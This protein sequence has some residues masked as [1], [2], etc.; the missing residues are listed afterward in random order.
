MCLERRATPSPSNKGV[1]VTLFYANLY[2]R[3]LWLDFSAGETFHSGGQDLI[4]LSV[5]RVTLAAPTWL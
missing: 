1:A 3:H 2:E 5:G 4:T